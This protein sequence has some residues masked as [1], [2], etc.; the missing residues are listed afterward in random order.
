MVWNTFW[1]SFWSTWT[2]KGPLP[3]PGWT[4][5]DFWLTPPPPLLVHVVVECP[6][7][8]CLSLLHL[9]GGR[10][11]GSAQSP[12]PSAL[13]AAISLGMHQPTT[14]LTF[15]IT[16]GKVLFIFIFC[17]FYQKNYHQLKKPICSC[18]L[19]RMITLLFDF[20][21]TFNPTYCSSHLKLDE[22]NVLWD[23]FFWQKYMFC[24]LWITV[25]QKWGHGN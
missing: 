19:I 5:V 11:G 14:F 2:F 21:V 3:T 4:S 6:L 16:S 15:T 12:N 24:G 17:D 8:F 20:L 10:G 9:V 25:L 23:H 1:K 18:N 22:N 7:L 13:S